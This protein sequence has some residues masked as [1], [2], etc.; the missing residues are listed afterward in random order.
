MM[1]NI[2]IELRLNAKTKMFNKSFAINHLDAIEE[3][4]HFDLL[5][6]AFNALKEK[7]V[8]SKFKAIADNCYRLKTLRISFMQLQQFELQQKILRSKAD[9]V[10]RMTESKY[11]WHWRQAYLK[12]KEKNQAKEYL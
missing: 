5:Q 11:L 7:V 3:E 10:L 4:N 9:E 6:I 12:E 8:L 1:R 2:I